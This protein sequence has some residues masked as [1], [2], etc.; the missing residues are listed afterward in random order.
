[1]DYFDNLV[2]AMIDDVDTEATHHLAVRL[3]LPAKILHANSGSNKHWFKKSEEIKRVK[4]DTALIFKSAIGDWI[5]SC[6]WTHAVALEEYVLRPG[7]SGGPLVDARGRLV[8]INT[9][10]AGPDVGLAVPV[11]VVKK[12][13][14]ENLGSVGQPK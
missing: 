7:Y 13:L 14:K 3:T 5:G 4:Y 9:I 11:H 8:G 10:M 12:F 6:P 1:M 2:Q